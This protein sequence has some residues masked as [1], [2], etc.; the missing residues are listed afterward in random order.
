M[1]LTSLVLCQFVPLDLTHTL[2]VEISRHRKIDHHVDKDTP[3]ALRCA[4]RLNGRFPLFSLVSGFA[5]S[6]DSPP[7]LFRQAA[8]ALDQAANFA[9]VDSQLLSDL[10]VGVTLKPQLQDLPL[11]RPKLIEEMVQLV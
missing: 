3:G 8:N 5:L 1:L 11:L 2:Q 7:F 9:V 6:F 10:A 4:S